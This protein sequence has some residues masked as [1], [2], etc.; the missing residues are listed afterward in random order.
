MSPAH[1]LTDSRAAEVDEPCSGQP[2]RNRF[3]ADPGAA[4]DAWAG[5]LDGV[6]ALTSSRGYRG[7][8]SGDAKPPVLRPGAERCAELPSRMGN[9]LHWPDGRTEVI[10]P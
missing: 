5:K 9:R 6:H 3:A 2:I 10:E 1:R 7:M 8:G 4:L